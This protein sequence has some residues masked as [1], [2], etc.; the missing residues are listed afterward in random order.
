MKPDNLKVGVE[1]RIPGAGKGKVQTR[2]IT[3]YRDADPANGRPFR[4][5]LV[6]EQWLTYAEIDARYT[7]S[8]PDSKLRGRKA[9][10]AK[11]KPGHE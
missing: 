1:L 6:N 2:T 5:W 11:A 7:Y 9:P 4:Q 10:N 3:D 8:K